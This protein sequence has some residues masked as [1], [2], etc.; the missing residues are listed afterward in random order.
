MLLEVLHHTRLHTLVIGGC[1]V[2]RLETNRDAAVHVTRTQV[3]GHDDDGVLEVHHATLRVGQA[4]VFQDLQQRVE[5][6]GVSLLH[7]VEQ[8]HGE[9][10]AADL[11]GQLAALIVA[12]VAGR[13]T[14][15]TGDGVLLLVLGHIQGDERI[16]IAEQ[17]L[18]KCLG[19][20]G[21][22][23][24]G[25]AGEDERTTGA[26]RVLQTCAGT[27]DRAGQC[28]NS[29]ILTNDALVELLLHGQQAAGLFLGDLVD[30]NTGGSRQ[31]LRNNLGGHGAECVAA[32]APCLLGFFLLSQDLLLLI[33]QACGL[34]VILGVDGVFLLLAQLGGL[35]IEQLDFRGCG[36]A[37]D[38]QTCARLVNQV[39][40]LIRQEAVRDVACRKVHG[41][42]NG[43]VGNG[44]AV[45]RLVLI[46]HTLEDLH[47]K[48][49]RGLL[50]LNRLE[51][52]LQSG[53]LLNVLAVLVQ[54]GCT[55]GLQFASSQHG[56][57]DGGSVNCAL[58]GTC[59]DEGVNLVNKQ[60][61][62][63]AG[64][65]LLQNL[66]QALFKVTAVART[67]DQG[68]QVQGVQVLVLEGFGDVTVHDSLCQALHDGGLTD[69]GL[70]NQHG[71]V[72][73]TAGEDLHDAFHL[74]VA[75]NDRVQLALTCCCGEVAAELIQDGRTRGSAFARVTCTHAGCFLFTGVVAGVT[76]NQVHN[77]LAHGSGLSAQLDQHLV[78]HAL[79]GTNHAQQDVFGADVAVVQLN[80]LAHGQFENL[81]RTRGE[82]DMAVRRL[83][84]GA[85]DVL[86]LL[87]YCVQGNA[88]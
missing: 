2:H 42:L 84:A 15:Q 67:C 40:S 33:T 31:N 59:T 81:L 24:T 25:R 27:A 88:Q 83:G 23:H 52:A 58:C 79:V 18:G 48:L 78:C 61:D 17:E 69:A 75:T 76:G 34:L 65:N 8:D 5:Q 32:F 37:L 63:A 45:V 73:G 12:N 66:L 6:V 30:G 49:L 44:D 85:D 53:V 13:R 4:T 11:L 64:A 16:L 77:S 50:N 71:V 3:G 10:L 20:L 29:V 35:L 55:D 26:A 80:S 19:K 39:D 72:L 51:A 38:A 22:T 46:A 21:L 36:H 62:V 41:S 28:R 87:T 57:E 86:N 9:G 54:G 56:L 7:L 43:L 74:L 82:G 70:T 60:D 1:V 47:G 68:A 14:E